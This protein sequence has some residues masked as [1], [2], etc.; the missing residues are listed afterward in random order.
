MTAEPALVAEG[1]HLVE[2]AGQRGIPLRL[3]GG[4]AVWIHSSP[5]A[6]EVLGRA[7]PDVDLVTRPQQGRGLREL[8]QALGYQPERTFN[9][10]HGARRLLYHAPGGGHHLDGF[11]GRFEMSHQLDLAPRLEVEAVTIPAAELLLTKLQVAE[12]NRKDVSDAVMLLLDHE[13]GDADGPGLLNVARIAELCAGDWGLHTTVSDNLVQVG[14]R[15]DQLLP[16]PDLRAQVPARVAALE[17]A[18]LAR[19]KTLRWKARARAGR[20]IRWYETPEEVSR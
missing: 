1:R 4:T 11:L 3:L 10:V 8:L 19:P 9:A 18:L 15:L 20:R 7:Y 5:R 6:R 16:Q 2:Q 17:A 12:L 13:L 14:A